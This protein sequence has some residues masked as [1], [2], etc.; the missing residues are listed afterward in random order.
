M[1]RFINALANVIIYKL[2]EDIEFQ[3]KKLNMLII[4]KD[5]KLFRI[6]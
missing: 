4:F 6:I 2:F 5:E 1:N 3:I